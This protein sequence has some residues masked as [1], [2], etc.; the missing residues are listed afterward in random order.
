MKTKK[1]FFVVLSVISVILLSSFI[2]TGSGN[3]AHFLKNNPEARANIIT[4][5]LKRKL[6]LD[7]NQFDKIYAI[8][9]KYA[10]LNQKYIDKM[11]GLES[12]SDVKITPEQKNQ[13]KQRKLELSDVLN[14]T[15]KMKVKDL[16]TKMIQHLETLL[17]TLK[18]NN[19]IE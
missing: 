13:L 9:L 1:K 12:I 19:E 2:H 18:E 15:Q 11:D 4:S 3:H 7:D 14:E 17:T 5:I 10:R 8:N 6:D 16:Q